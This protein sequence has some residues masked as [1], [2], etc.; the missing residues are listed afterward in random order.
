MKPTPPGWPRISTA[1]YYDDPAEAIDWLVEAFGFEVRIKVVH[2]GVVRHSELTFGDAVVMVA[3]PRENRKSPP[4]VGGANTQ[5][6]F[7]HVDDID[8]FVAHAVAAGAKVIQAPADHDYGE[9]YWT[10]RSAEL[11]DVGGHHWWFSQRLRT[12]GAV[13]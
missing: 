5:N 8:A 12:G 2:E 3:G 1:L 6:M 13:N 9:D 11:A 10:D 4:S 7:V